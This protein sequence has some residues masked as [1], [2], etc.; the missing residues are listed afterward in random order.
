MKKKNFI[1]QKR[2]LLAIALVFMLFLISSCSSTNEPAAN[3]VFIQ[4]MSYSPATLTVTAGTT[5]KWIN[6]VSD[7]HT[8][9]SDTGLFDSGNVSKNGVFSFTFMT[10]GTYSYHCTLHPSMKAKVVVN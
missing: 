6:K 7:T 4:S 3:E 8:V 5:V 10:A 9:T 2:G 1:Y